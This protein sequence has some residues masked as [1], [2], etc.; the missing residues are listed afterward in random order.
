MGLGEKDGEEFDQVKVALVPV[1]ETHV[2]DEFVLGGH[3]V[4]SDHAAVPPRAELHPDVSSDEMVRGRGGGRRGR[5]LGGRGGITVDP[6]LPMGQRG[7]RWW[8]MRERCIVSPVGDFVGR[9]HER[10]SQWSPLVPPP[11]YIEGR[12][13]SGRGWWRRCVQGPGPSGDGCGTILRD[14]IWRARADR[15]EG[16]GGFTRC[17]RRYSRRNRRGRVRVMVGVR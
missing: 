6:S 17:S 5:A 1:F 8:A 3:V 13:N 14:G 11:T 16:S 4:V 7:W 9:I 10:T 2:P 12:D 15:G